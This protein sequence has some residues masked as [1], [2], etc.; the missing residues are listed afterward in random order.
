ML[1][2]NKERLERWG[3]KRKAR[4]RDERENRVKEKGTLHIDISM[5]NFS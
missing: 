3:N 5:N 1:N 4:E 2:S